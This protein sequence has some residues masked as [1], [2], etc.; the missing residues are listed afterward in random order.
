M[1]KKILICAF[2]VFGTAK[3]KFE[4]KKNNRTE[5]HSQVQCSVK[6]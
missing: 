1:K 2:L 5:R 6:Q 4:I 3:L